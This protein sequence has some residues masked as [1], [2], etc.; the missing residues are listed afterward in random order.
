MNVM[1]LIVFSRYP[2]PGT[3]KTRLIPVL[4]TDGA[5]RLQCDLTRH[6]LAQAR[7]FRRTAAVTVEVRYDGGDAKKMAECFGNDVEYRPQGAGDL[8]CRMGRALADAFRD[9]A[10]RA[11]VVGADCP[12]ITPRLLREAFERLAD[13]D[14]ALGPATDGGYYLI[15]LR[16]LVPELFHAIAW[17][18]EHVLQSTLDRA[19]ELSQSVALLEPLS[20]VDRPEDLTVWRRIAA[21]G[22]SPP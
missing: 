14:V 5:A 16:R 11:V 6:T 7:A 15:G 8:G 3:T 1:R 22:G 21:E 19:A 2:E 13:A 4:G 9:G 12:G 17:G 10:A 18:G 20:D